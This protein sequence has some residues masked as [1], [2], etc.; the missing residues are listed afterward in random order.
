MEV[1][2][3]ERH[4]EPYGKIH[5]VWIRRK[6]VFVPFETQEEATKALECTQMSKILDMVVS[7]EYALRDDDERRDRFDSAETIAE[8][9]PTMIR[10]ALAA[11]LYD[12]YNG[13]MY[14]EARIPG[15]GRYRR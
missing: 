5:H 10:D 9:D 11:R 14:E 1:C 8:T 12:R 13:P 15:Y 6:F 2:D 7:F 3:I 4:F